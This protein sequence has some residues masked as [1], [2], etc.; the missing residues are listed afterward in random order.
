MRRTAGARHTLGA[1]DRI[2]L[3]RQASF[4]QAADRFVY[5]YTRLRLN[6]VADSIFEPPP[7]RP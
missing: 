5:D 6:A 3:F 4:A 2:R 7:R 1:G